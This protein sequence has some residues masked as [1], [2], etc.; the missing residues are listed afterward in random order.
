[1]PEDLTL[2]A[3]G[4]NMVAQI[5]TRSIPGASVRRVPPAARGKRLIVEPLVSLALPLS[6]ETLLADRVFVGVDVSK[7]WVDFADAHGRQ[8][9]VA[10]EYAPLKAALLGPWSNCANMVCEATGGYER[11][12]MRVA[13]EVG[14]P[15]RRVHPNRARAFAQATARLAKTD[16][17]DARTLAK[18]AAFTVDEPWAPLPDPKA[19]ELAD[20]VSRLTQ[21]IDLHQSEACR[22]KALVGPAIKRSILAV[23]KVIKAQ[24]DAMQEAIDA[25][26]AADP[27]LRENTKILRSCKG[28]GPK[29]A[30]A[31]LGML[32][33]IGALN[34]RKI[35]ALV[36]VAPITKSSGSS[37]NHA[38]IAGGRK[39]LRDILFMAALTASKHN[40]TFTAFYARLRASGKPHKLALIAV[41]RKLI[42]TL[43]AMINSRQM[44]NSALT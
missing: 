13:R 26:V 29:S 40:P 43:N 2:L 12:L 15:L 30:Q 8:E 22:V 31:I 42:I 37:L 44:F 24:I 35:A 25:F 33:E 32:P 34:R 11:V 21:M 23:M 9:R 5:S 3:K 6:P 18:F 28:V 20:M 7:S 14:A 17:L 4:S 38:S 27:V 36:G 1:V 39:A 16:A 19:Q 41:L 10:N